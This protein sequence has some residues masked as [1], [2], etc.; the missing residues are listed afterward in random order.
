MLLLLIS[1]SQQTANNKQQTN[2]TSPRILNSGTSPSVS[3]FFAWTTSYH[4][5]LEG[6]VVGQ[7]RA[8]RSQLYQER[9]KGKAEG[10]CAHRELPPVLEM[11]SSASDPVR[12]SK[13]STHDANTSTDLY[14]ESIRQEDSMAVANRFVTF[15]RAEAQLSLADAYVAS[16]LIEREAREALMLQETNAENETHR[17]RRKEIK[18]FLFT[19]VNHLKDKLVEVK[20][21]KEARETATATRLSI[22]QKREAYTRLAKQLEDRERDERNKLRDG[23]ERTS[24]NLIIWQEL[25]LREMDKE[26][27]DS[28]RPLNKIKAQQ[29]REVQ[30]KEAEQ[31]REL[32]HLK[33]K[34]SLDQFNL[35]MEFIERVEG[36]KAQQLTDIQVAERKQKLQ[37]QELKQRIEELREEAKNLK[38]Q[39]LNKLRSEQIFEQQQKKSRE[40]YEAQRVLR[41]ERERAFD[42]EVT[43]RE[44]ALRDKLSSMKEGSNASG[45]ESN[46]RSEKGSS[47][48]GASDHAGS[49]T[50][51]GVAD[52]DTMSEPG[53]QK[54]MDDEEDETL[55]RTDTAV[56]DVLKKIE[57]DEESG[58]NEV[59]RRQ[60][61]HRLQAEKAME[62]A[63][64]MLTL[65]KA[66]HD[67]D[68]TRTVSEQ[69]SNIKN[70]TDDFDSSRAR[71]RALNEQKTVELITTHAREKADILR[72]QQRELQSVQKSI[73]LERQLHSRSLSETQVAS[74]AKSEFLSF[75]CHELRNP[76]SGIVAIVDML[77]RTNDSLSSEQ[78]MHIDTI[79]SESELMCAIVNDVLDFAKIEANMLTLDLAKMDVHRTINEMVAE[80]HLIAK[81]TKP[82]VNVI[83]DIAE[84]VPHFVVTDSIRLRQVLLNLISNAIK[85]TFQGNITVRVILVNVVSERSQAV[86]KFEVEDT[87][88]GISAEDQQHV[89]SAFSQANPSTTREFGGTGLG[90]S[91]SRALVERL[92]GT[93]TLHSEKGVG[94]CFAFTIT[95]EIVSADAETERSTG[96][97]GGKGKGI[98][99]SAGSG[100]GDAT[101]GEVKMPEGL[102][103]LVVEDSSTLRRLWAKLL[104]EQSCIVETATNGMDAVEKCALRVYDLVL[105]DI[106]MPVMSGDVA[107]AKLR[108]NNYDGIVIAL[109][110]NAMEEDKERYLQAGMDAVVTK[111][112]KMDELR[113]VIARLL[114]K[115]GKT[116]ESSSGV[117]SPSSERQQRKK[118]RGKGKSTSSEETPPSSSAGSVA[119]EG[120]GDEPSLDTK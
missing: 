36:V 61:L 71:A 6:R 81:R 4:L 76:L 45:S 56:T 48:A 62:Q 114:A 43:A 82:E 78:R 25:E 38:E 5:D 72:A 49:E 10:L 92:G 80:Q 24:K 105:M 29:L 104:T 32:Q 107:V 69:A 84:D 109:T 96:G 70:M 117:P 74:Q 20:H 46:Q 23:H 18:T 75:V 118:K 41:L 85:F 91:I 112:F 94:T 108:Q 1:L 60:D 19:I 33:A 31:L 65:Q 67:Q 15:Q 58:V 50:H 57:A 17:R 111:P 106:T 95:G 27:R 119:S 99:S 116:A 68:R 35:E 97:A 16:N 79:K 120:G 22:R 86:V 110:A 42:L 51:S 9:G 59:G 90:L 103:V 64:T 98:A 14:M 63:I 7:V 2:K 83:A 77:L 89:F 37:K 26:T 88:V 93:I 28:V 87:G 115:K 39:E 55:E 113:S 54:T 13:T 44:E 40:L 53:S 21:L 34:F 8:A 3:F 47:V 101:Q 100:E 30:Q 12:S 52:D 11:S 66:Q 73:E 102:Q